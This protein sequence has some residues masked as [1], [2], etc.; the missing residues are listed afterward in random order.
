MK[1]PREGHWCASKRVS[2]YL[3]GIQDF[4]LKYFKVEDLKLVGHTDSNF[5]GDKENG[6]STSGYLVSLGS[7]YISLTSHKQFVQE[8]FATKVEYVVIV[9]ETKEIV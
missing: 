2:R 5:D 1:K 6:V 8:N 9:E 4:G 3:K 7:I